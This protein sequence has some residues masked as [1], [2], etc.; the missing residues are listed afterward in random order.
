MCKL[1]FVIPCY[2]SAK[3]IGLVL[4]EIE[5]TMTQK[6]NS[7]YE[8]ITVVDG[9][10]DNVAEVLR[11]R[12]AQDAHLLVI[13][14]SRNFGQHNALMAGYNYA[15]G[16]IVVSL[17]DDGQCPVDRVWELINPLESGEADM[18]AARYY[19]KKQSGFKNF[20]SRVNAAMA[21]ALI[22]IP[23]KFEMSNF[24]A[25]NKIVCTNIVQY[26]NPY[27]YPLGL[28]SNVTKRMVNVPMEERERAHG[29]TNYT[30]RGL[31]KL[32]LNGFTSFSVAPLRMAD[33][34]GTVCAFLGFIYGLYIIIRQL[35]FNDV[36]LGYSSLIAIILFMGGLTMILLGLLGE[37]IG[38]IFICINKQPQY[39]VRSAISQDQSSRADLFNE[40]GMVEGHQLSRS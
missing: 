10:P 40:E 39:V 8:V 27:S 36:A 21:H 19:E 30:F 12:S 1:S 3:T 22:G 13:E 15:S 37:Y 17:D 9:S 4:D 6:P 38:R 16:D 14:L 5:S 32:W 29:T 18:V 7:G 31:L 35:V 20:G 33:V 34:V 23:K 28:I 2:N 25:F 24:F 11:E 26:K